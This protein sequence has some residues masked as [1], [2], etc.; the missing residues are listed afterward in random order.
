MRI[1]KVPYKSL[2]AAGM[3]LVAALAAA[4]GK[5]GATPA[6]YQGKDAK[7]AAESLL[8]V[9]EQLAEEGSWELIAIGRVHY[10]N[11]NKEK[12][13]AF[14]NRAVSKK[15]AVSDWRR[16]AAIYTDAKDYDKAIS[17]LEKALVKS[18]KDS[19][20]FAELGAAYNLKGDR[21]KAEEMFA[22]SFANDPG[23]FWNTVNVAGSYLGVIPD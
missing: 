11:G 13:E 12:G 3:M 19:K 2:I 1:Q 5:T 17:T 15:A 18:P 4:G 16:I 9:A 23:S 7:D 20:L 21:A 22:Q 8:Q 14:F 6:L 10:L